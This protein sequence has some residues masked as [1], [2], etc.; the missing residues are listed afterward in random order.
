MTQ[1]QIDYAAQLYA[2]RVQGRDEKK[3]A[4]ADFTAG[5]T[6]VNAELY[7]LLHRKVYEIKQL[8]KEIKRLRQRPGCERSANVAISN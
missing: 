3:Y 7:K 8:N 5:A 4:M 1:G 2:K 6:Y